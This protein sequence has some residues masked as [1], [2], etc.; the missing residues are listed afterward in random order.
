MYKRF[1]DI[2]TT[3]NSLNKKRYSV[4]STMNHGDVLHVMKMLA[5]QIQPPTTV[6]T[7]CTQ[8]TCSDGNLQTNTITMSTIAKAT[9]KARAK[10]KEKALA[11]TMAIAM[12]EAQQRIYGLDGSSAI[13]GATSSLTMEPTIQ[14]AVEA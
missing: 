7:D 11:M 5:L 6:A 3:S 13:G 2:D 9:A 4:Y 8:T 1:K 10:A 14:I 12:V